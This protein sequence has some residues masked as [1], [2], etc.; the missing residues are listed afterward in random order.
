MSS[1]L[2][3]LRTRITLIQLPP[4]RLFRPLPR[5]HHRPLSDITL[6]RVS[7]SI[8]GE[9]SNGRYATGRGKYVTTVVSKLVARNKRS[10]LL[11]YSVDDSRATGW[12]GVSREQSIGELSWLGRE[13]DDDD[14]SGRGWRLYCGQIDICKTGIAFSGM[15]IRQFAQVDNA[16]NRANSRVSLLVFPV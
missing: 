9:D 10:P 15:R 3:Q 11:I 4:Y 13:D 2:R 7:F 1:L 12:G 14:S 6:A 16:N 8:F 5:H